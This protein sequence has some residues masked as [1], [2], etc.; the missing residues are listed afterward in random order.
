[1]K[2][3]LS[4]LVSLL[5]STSVVQALP[6]LPAASRAV[7][8]D[9]DT[10]AARVNSHDLGRRQ[11]II[12]VGLGGFGDPGSSAGG[13]SGEGEPGDINLGEVPTKKKKTKGAAIQPESAPV[14]DSGNGDPAPFPGDPDT[15]PAEKPKA[16]ASDDTPGLGI[17]A[18][19]TA[20]AGGVTPPSNNA[21]PF[22]GSR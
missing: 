15:A 22:P 8:S 1:M 16:A 4:L 2:I 19:F 3:T 21:A 13:G 9:L 17:S 6:L 12:E 20:P 5:A 11:G 10:I 7:S 18:T 14:P